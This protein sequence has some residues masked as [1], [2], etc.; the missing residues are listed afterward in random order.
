MINLNEH[1]K[2][3][4][5]VK[6]VPLEIADKAIKEVFSYNSRLDKEMTKVE[7]YLK[8]ITNTLNTKLDND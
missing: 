3:V 1:I 4:D 2:V 7:G 8:N 5:G 6:Y